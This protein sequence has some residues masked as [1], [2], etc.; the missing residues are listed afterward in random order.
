MLFLN[1]SL[2][3]K[4]SL[5]LGQYSAYILYILLLITILCVPKIKNAVLCRPEVF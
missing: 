2:K 5:L 1:L 3:C 4:N